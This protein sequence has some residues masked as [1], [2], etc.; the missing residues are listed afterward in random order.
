MDTKL[1]SIGEILTKGWD[2]FSKNYQ[3][4]ITPVLIMIAPSIL[5][6]LA[7]FYTG[8]GY[9]LLYIVLFVLMILVSIWISIVLVLMI[10]KLSKGE[11]VEIN[12]LYETS[13][14]KIPSYLLVAILTALAIFGGF[15]LLIIPGII[16]SIWFE[17]S[18]YINL[19]ENKNNKGIAAL[20][21]SKELVSGR[22]WGVLIRL[23][24]PALAVYLIII[25]VMVVLAIIVPILAGSLN[26]YAQ[27][28]ITNIISSIISLAITPLMLIFGIILY[29]SLKATKQTPVIQPTQPTKS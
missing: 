8:P 17:F 6:S 25:V 24:V 29:N 4:F 9:V 28:M 11:S 2:L 20:K 22:W 27:M 7:M 23:I 12:K 21:S 13:F 16:F 15:I 1:V 14:A 19:L 26:E 3:Q 18:A 10:D 5:Y